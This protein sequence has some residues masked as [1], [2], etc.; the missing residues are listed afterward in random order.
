MAAPVLAQSAIG[1][2]QAIT[3]SLQRSDGVLEDGSYYD[4]YRLQGTA[5]RPVIVSLASDDFDTY[6]A[7]VEGSE[8]RGGDT[9][10]TDDDGGGDTNSRLMFTPGN[11]SYSIRANS[12]RDG[13]TG[14]YRLS[15]SWGP[16]VV[17]TVTTATP[18]ASLTVPGYAKGQLG[19]GDRVA[20]DDSYYDC[21]AFDAQAGRTLEIGM[22]SED[23][24]TYVSLHDGGTCDAEIDSNDDGFEEGTDSLLQ[25]RVA[26]AGRYS[27]RANSLSSDETGDYEIIIAFE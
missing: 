23:F 4:C 8:C 6:L 13:E 3:G 10:D 12:L 18:V 20:D 17:T 27:V 19:A 14:A 11:G 15:V 2:G 21:Y 26:R 5:G 7:V 24:D 22:A 16:A 25:H 1:P 9:V